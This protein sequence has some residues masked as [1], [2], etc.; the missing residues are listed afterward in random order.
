M[1]RAGGMTRTALAHGRRCRGQ[2]R[3]RKKKDGKHPG[4]HVMRI[5]GRN[6]VRDNPDSSKRDNV[7]R[8]K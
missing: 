5:N 2:R 7:N 4:A 6:F 1:V 8:N 3:F